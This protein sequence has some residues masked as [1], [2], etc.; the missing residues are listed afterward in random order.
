[1]HTLF[2]DYWTVSVVN[3]GQYASI[4]PLSK[5]RVVELKSGF[6]DPPLG[7]NLHHA[8]SNPLSQN[9]HAVLHTLLEDYWAVSVVNR[10][11]YAP[12]G[13]LSKLRVVELKSGFSDPCWENLHLIE[14]NHVVP[15][16]R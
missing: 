14:S 8:E 12:I 7:E 11:Q 9:R 1:M 3:R 6:W 15:T 2:E 13:R 5:L 16:V 10:G 4:G